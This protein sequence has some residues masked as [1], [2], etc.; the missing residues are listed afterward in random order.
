MSGSSSIV[1]AGARFGPLGS[2]GSACGA[3]DEKSASTIRIAA[4]LSLGPLLFVEFCTHCYELER[5][6]IVVGS[7]KPKSSS[8]S[9]TTS[10]LSLAQLSMR[11]FTTCV[12]GMSFHAPHHALS[13]ASRVNALLMSATRRASLAIPPSTDGWKFYQEMDVGDGCV[14]GVPRDEIILGKTLL[15]ILSLAISSESSCNGNTN[16]DSLTTHLCLFS[17]LLSNCM[18]GEA[19]ECCYLISAAA[20]AFSE[21]NLKEQLGVTLL[22]GFEFGSE[23]TGANV[24][25][26][27]GL[28]HSDE[29]NDNTCVSSAINVAMKLNCGL[30][31]NTHVPLP[32]KKCLSGERLRAARSTMGLPMTL[33]ENWPER[34][35]GRLEKELHSVNGMVGIGTQIGKAI[36]SL[37]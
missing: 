24:V 30:D 15:P 31:G 37:C 5:T 21:P 6:S 12:R 13:R 8:H 16:D 35:Q 22:R 27:L 28:D 18:Y 36:L 23:G 4:S 7:N 33:V 14:E 20:E 2:E 32:G 11:A 25:G 10:E 9:S 29:S 3:M 1:K 19:M 34:H 26:V 17:E